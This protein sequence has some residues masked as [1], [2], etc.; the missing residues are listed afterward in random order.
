ME[1]AEAKSEF[2]VGD[3]E[4]PPVCMRRSSTGDLDPAPGGR[5][6]SSPEAGI[7]VAASSHMGAASAKLGH[8]AHDCRRHHEALHPIS[9]AH[10]PIAK[11][12]HPAGAGSSWM[13]LP[14]SKPTQR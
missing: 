4:L 9:N 5:V 7:R 14:M 6:S 12:L 1:F 13:G 8:L 11:I 10:V 3:Q 2:V